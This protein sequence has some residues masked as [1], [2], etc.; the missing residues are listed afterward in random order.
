M[1][2]EEEIFERALALT[3]A[4]ARADY[5]LKAC[6]GNSDLRRRVKE[7]LAA[8]HDAR[9]IEF[10]GAGDRTQKVETLQAEDRLSEKPGD[11]IGHYKLLQQIGEGGC[12]VVYMAEQQE[13]VRRRVALKVIKLG[14]DTKTVIARFE[15]ER[16]VLAL[17]DHPNIAKVH[18]AGATETGRPYFVMELV[19]GVKI[20]EYC[21]QNRLSTRERLELAVQV[22]HA[23]QHAHQKGIIHRDIK[24]SNILV[25][26]ADDKPVPKVIDFGIAKATAHQTLT[27]K[28]LFTAIEQFIG[29]PAYMSPEQAGMSPGGGGDIDTR[30]DIYSL[31]VLL[32]ELLTGS[33]PFDTKELLESG[34]DHMRQIIREREPVRPST[35]LRHTTSSASPSQLVTRH[36][37]LATD[38]DWIV[39]KCLEKDRTRRYETA[40]GLAQ[41]LERHMQHEPVVARPPS[42]AYRVQKFVRR[43]KL[44]VATG[45]AVALVLVLGLAASIWQGLRAQ[46][47]REESDAHS[48]AAD[49]YLAQQALKADDLGK[50]RT[51]L[52]RYRPGTGREQLRGWEWRFLWQEC[53]SDAL[54]ELCRF[55]K[56]AFRV[57][58]SPDGSRLAIAGYKREFI[59]MWDVPAH[60]RIA[61]LQTNT[62]RVVAF[63]AKGDLLATDTVRGTNWII[64]IWQV[65][66]ANLVRQI[67]NWAG[68]HSVGPVA[69]KFSPDGTQL[70][71]LNRG[72]NVARWDVK[73]WK[74]LP[75]LQTPKR[76]VD[77]GA[78]EFSPDGQ[79]LAVGDDD[80]AIRIFHP[81]TGET[82]RT[83]KAHQQ[84]ISAL[85]WS[86]TASI[87][88]S[89]SAYAGGPVRL[90]DLNTG[91]P[92]GELQ[93]H[94]GWI[95]QL[96]F[97]TDGHLLYSA[98][99]DQTIRIWEVETKELLVTLRGSTDEVYSLALSPD[100]KTLASG[101]K[102]GVVAFWSASPAGRRHLVRHCVDISGWYSFAPDGRSFAAPVKGIVRLFEMPGFTPIGDLPELGTNVWCVTH[103]L[104]GTLIVSGSEDGWLRVWARADR[105]LVREIPVYQGEEISPFLFLP[106][107]RLV[108]EGYPRG[109][110]IFWDTRTWQRLASFAAPGGHSYRVSPDGR[111]ALTLDSARQLTWW[112]TVNGKLLATRSAHR[113][114]CWGYAFSPDAKVVASVSE[115]NSVA[116]WEAATFRL[117]AAFRAH[118]NGA[119]AV[120]FS[121]D[122]RRLVTGGSGTDSIKLWD[123]ATRRELLTFSEQVGGQV[124]VVGFSPDGNWLAGWDW[125][126]KV[127]LYRAPSWEEIAAAEAQ[128][129]H[130]SIRIAT[131]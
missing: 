17:M 85:A 33:T 118:R 61:I 18:D 47:A 26:M 113:L 129:H 121:P 97:S 108:S 72:G 74:R 76:A 6:A 16:Q 45:A 46:R 42:T 56:P 28:T 62:G 7:L 13:P 78:M 83:I 32:Y 92:V 55:S 51:L 102:D 127:Y 53:R 131:E 60:R 9:A 126:G 34:L 95:C 109:E 29:T 48:Y 38:L 123:L 67:T 82:N 125:S 20:T 43:N 112:D 44:I 81:T 1:K 91:E 103:S 80:G 69:L 100:G 71:S 88:A 4:E 75:D 77:E 3:S 11:R 30:S 68:A 111:V 24:P 114:P 84:L 21:D 105:R 50:A 106:D 12:G 40:N 116:L 19:Q 36:S 66:S 89:G 87:L 94:T 63:S 54:G 90:W 59:E 93:G 122:G 86:P 22:C 10:L 104:D 2:R 101:S 37:P 52:D 128:D 70:M 98:S 8:H 130:A 15:A 107:G 41:D 79:R 23:I 96:I 5:L 115:D 120:A 124:L 64:N 39:M 73:D 58:Y 14:M 35:R 99:A 65:G 27:D 57:A 49:M 31:G 110:L 119:F 117:M 25:M